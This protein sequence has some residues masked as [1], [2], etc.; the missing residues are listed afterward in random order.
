MV[1]TTSRTI[2]VAR[3]CTCE[4]STNG[5]NNGNGIDF[6]NICAS[7]HYRNMFSLQ[8]DVTLT[9]LLSI[10]EVFAQLDPSSMA[11]ILSESIGKVI[12]MGVLPTPVVD[13]FLRCVSKE[14]IKSIESLV[15]IKDIV[16][17]GM[18]TDPK[19]LGEFFMRVGKDE[20]IFLGKDL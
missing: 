12:Y 17:I 19:V 5:N 6:P 4:K 16:V 11:A 8:V 18:T 2:R 7:K 20:L 9:K 15:S 1:G 3:N 10:K 14:V 13:H